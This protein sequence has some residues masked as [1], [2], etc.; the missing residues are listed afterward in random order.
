MLS[1][2][3]DAIYKKIY[4]VV[5]LSVEAPHFEA[6]ELTKIDSVKIRYVCLL[7]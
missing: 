6:L 1:M 7:F 4:D 5:V 2:I 3:F